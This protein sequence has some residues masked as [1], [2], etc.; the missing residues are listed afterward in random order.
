MF[1]QCLWVDVGSV[2]FDRGVALTATYGDH[3]ARDFASQQVI[4]EKKASLTALADNCEGHE[5][6]A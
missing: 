1:G 2:D 6:T 5:E 3:F 4:V